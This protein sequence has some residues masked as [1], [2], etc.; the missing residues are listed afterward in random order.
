MKLGINSAIL[1]HYTLEEMVKFVSDIGYESIEVACWPGGTVERKYAGVSHID[2][3]T[4]NETNKK[5]FSTLIAL[6]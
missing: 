6:N 4:L 3:N 1:G 5:I 2:V